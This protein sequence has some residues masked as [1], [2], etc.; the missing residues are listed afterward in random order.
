[1]SKGLAKTRRALAM[2]RAIMNV[3]QSAGYRTRKPTSGP[4]EH[5]S[6]TLLRCWRCGIA[7]VLV[8]LRQYL[9][10]LLEQRE[11]LHYD[12][13]IK[14]GLHEMVARNESRLATFRID[15]PLRVGN[16]RSTIYGDALQCFPRKCG[17][18]T[19]DDVYGAADIQPGEQVVVVAPLSHF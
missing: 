9:N 16:Q 18:F 6:R 15:T 2:V 19:R 13:G 7:A 5:L 12:S 4:T 11:I 17:G 3:R 10:E 14:R 1:M 8:R